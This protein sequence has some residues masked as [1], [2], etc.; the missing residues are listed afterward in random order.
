ME[1]NACE[2]CIHFDSLFYHNGDF[3]KCC[4]HGISVFRR[5][6][7]CKYFEELEKEV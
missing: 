3:G 2:N 5:A 1:E 7:T 6:I 4:K